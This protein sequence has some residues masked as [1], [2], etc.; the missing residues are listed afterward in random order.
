MILVTEEMGMTGDVHFALVAVS[1]FGL[2]VTFVSY[3]QHRAQQ[4][5][6]D[7]LTDKLMSRSYVEYKSI[8]APKEEDASPIREEESKGWYDH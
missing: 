7:R 3:L 2:V 6:I 8:G 5:T 4:E 1:I